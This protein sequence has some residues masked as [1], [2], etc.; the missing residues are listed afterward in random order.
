M[1][2]G[3]FKIRHVRA[4]SSCVI[5]RNNLWILIAATQALRAVPGLSYME[6]ER[7]VKAIAAGMQAIH[8]ATAF[9]P[10]LPHEIDLAEQLDAGQE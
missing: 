8:D 1:T 5:G 2:G 9:G 3:V 4:K 10:F 6:D 7:V